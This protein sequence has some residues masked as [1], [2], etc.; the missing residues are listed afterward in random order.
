MSTGTEIKEKESKRYNIHLKSNANDKIIED[1]KNKG[2]HV[3]RWKDTMK[4]VAVRMTAE[5]V[6]LVKEWTDTVD[7]IEEMLA[8]PADCFFLKT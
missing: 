7:K 2:I 5:Q 4:E 6:S 8:L 1:L 3:T